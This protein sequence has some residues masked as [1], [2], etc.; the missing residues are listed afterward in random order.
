M[1]CKEDAFGVLVQRDSGFHKHRSESTIVLG[2]ET[3]TKDPQFMEPPRLITLSCPILI[4]LHHNLRRP[5]VSPQ[6]QQPI[7]AGWAG[8]N[9]NTWFLRCYKSG[10]LRDA[11]SVWH[12]RVIVTCKFTT[13]FGQACRLG[14]CFKHGLGTLRDSPIVQP[15]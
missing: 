8:R 10:K 14:L 12:M 4:S 15:S 5:R 11:A 2:M 6:K 7:G 9:K 3:P 13:F 1:T